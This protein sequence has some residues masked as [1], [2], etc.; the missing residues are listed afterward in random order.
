MPSKVGQTANTPIRW[1]AFGDLAASRP[2]LY[3]VDWSA[4]WGEIG[5]SSF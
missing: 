2:D 4:F 3:L 1:Y 5:V